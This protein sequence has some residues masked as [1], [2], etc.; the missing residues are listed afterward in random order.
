MW[1]PDLEDWRRTYESRLG[2]WLSATEE[3][4][5]SMGTPSL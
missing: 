5:A 1:S 4:E 2:I 3:A